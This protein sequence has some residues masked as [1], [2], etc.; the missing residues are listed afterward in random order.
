M[1]PFYNDM[2][3]DNCHICYCCFLS[4]K[5]KQSLENEIHKLIQIVDK[6]KIDKTKFS[7]SKA[8]SVSDKTLPVKL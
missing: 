2:T 6:T 1:L 8:T 5:K 3:L 7:Q 4:L